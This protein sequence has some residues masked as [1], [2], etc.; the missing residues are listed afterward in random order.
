MES[1]KWS[2]NCGDVFLLLFFRVFA[3]DLRIT[4]NKRPLCV[5]VQC[6]YVVDLAS[7]SSEPLHCLPGVM[8]NAD[9]IMTSHAITFRDPETGT[10]YVQTQL[11]QVM[12]IC[13][14]WLLYLIWNAALW[15]WQG[16]S[17]RECY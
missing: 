1:H 11:M 7:L 10:I 14:P 8:L 15:K 4:V 12:I 13:L 3:R 5:F 17:R 16:L 6:A 9:E 2:F